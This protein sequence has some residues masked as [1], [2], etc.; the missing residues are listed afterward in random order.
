MKH[1][2][3]LS[4]IGL[5]MGALLSTG[6]SASATIL[7]SP[8]G[9]TYTGKF[10]AESTTEVQIHR[11]WFGGMFN[12]TCPRARLEGQVE[13]HGVAI[14]ATIRITSTQF[15]ECWT[16]FQGVTETFLLKPGLLEIHTGNEGTN[17]TVTYT[18]TTFELTTK[19]SYPEHC[20]Y[21]LSNSD[22]GSITGSKAT[23]G[24]AT[25]DLRASLTSLACGP[26]ELT[27]SY[28]IT[29]PDNFNVD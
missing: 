12:V 18:G 23:G 10:V 19:T 6:G 25:F 22:I 16:P 8:S 17:G 2:R 7:T 24:T 14:T 3:T 13:N 5:V 15:I 11:Q 1:L 26:A 27:G 9:T 20:V 29:T 4:L 21:D 28:K